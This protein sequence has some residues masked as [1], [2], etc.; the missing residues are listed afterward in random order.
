MIIDS[1]LGKRVWAEAVNF[2]TF[3]INTTKTIE[4]TG[5]SPYEIV[6]GQKPYLG[7]VRRFGTRCWFYNLKPNK[8]KLD[9][10]AIAG[11]IVGIDEDGLSY[12]VLQLGTPNVIRIRDVRTNKPAPLFNE[13]NQLPSRTTTGT[14]PTDM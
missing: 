8:D 1:Q 7:R 5:K 11:A 2:A 14:E 12:R 6:T 4:P 9:E 10:R 13:E 3:A